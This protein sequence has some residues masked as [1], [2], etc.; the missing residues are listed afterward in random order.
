MIKKPKKPKKRF[1]TCPDCEA[2]FALDKG[3]PFPPHRWLVGPCAGVGK[4]AN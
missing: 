1:R 2:N 3:E 4:P